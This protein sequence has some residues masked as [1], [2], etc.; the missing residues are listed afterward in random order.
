MGRSRSLRLPNAIALL[1]FLPLAFFDF[2]DRTN[3]PD[4]QLESVCLIEASQARS[5][6]QSELPAEFYP[7]ALLFQRY[8]AIAAHAAISHGRSRYL[9]NRGSDI[10]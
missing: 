6:H 4:A 10:G 2:G 8:D 1:H 5:R 9:R 3:L 7:G